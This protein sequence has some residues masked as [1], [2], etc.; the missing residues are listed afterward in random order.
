MEII[1]ENKKNHYAV[2]TENCHFFDKYADSIRVLT[3]N[4]FAKVVDQDRRDAFRYEELH[5]A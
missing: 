4:E 5:A 3:K 2:F 1:F